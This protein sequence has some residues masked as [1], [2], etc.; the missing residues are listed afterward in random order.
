MPDGL[1]W[2]WWNKGRGKVHSKCNH[3]ET[4]SLLC[5]TLPVCGK[6]VFHETCPWGPKDWK[7][8]YSIYQENCCRRQILSLL[9]RD[10]CCCEEVR[11][12]ILSIGLCSLLF[13]INWAQNQIQ[14]HPPQRVGG[15]MVWTKCYGLVARGD[16]RPVS[17]SPYHCVDNTRVLALGTHAARSPASLVAVPVCSRVLLEHQQP[18]SLSTACCS[19]LFPPLILCNFLFSFEGT[20]D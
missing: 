19:Y 18:K 8:E 15:W 11:N 20:I 1:R 7:P 9:P 17:G 10:T 16:G 3:P 12:L 6:I 13:S 14:R 5:P 2:S 4:S